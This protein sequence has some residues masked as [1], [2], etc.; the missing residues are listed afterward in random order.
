MILLR[1]VVAVLAM[2]AVLAVP[3]SGTAAHRSMPIDDFM[4][5]VEAIGADGGMDC[6]ACNQMPAGSA[7]PA[8]PC[9]ILGILTYV[10]VVIKSGRPSFFT[11]QADLLQQLNLVPPTP[12]A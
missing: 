1:R 11:V 6:K 9:A 8:S 10:S 5:D 12:P 2:I 7:C 4:S 3:L